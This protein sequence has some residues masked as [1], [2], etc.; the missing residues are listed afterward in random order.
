ME[1]RIYVASSWRNVAY[2]SVVDAL[3]E[4]GHKAYDFRHPDGPDDEYGFHW[5]DIDPNWKNW[6]KEKFREALD[7]P[8]ANRGYS[9]DLM[10][11]EWC[12][13]C[14]LV[15]PCGR[16]A[17]SELGWCA[18]TGKRTI[19]LLSDGEPELMYK[20]FDHICVSVKEVLAVLEKR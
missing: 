8:I 3:R 18:G 14:V 1:R 19:V 9:R 10:A 16:S 17:H 6:S 15:L 7:H 4:A 2:P 5:S 13:D 12:Q 11:M 20:L